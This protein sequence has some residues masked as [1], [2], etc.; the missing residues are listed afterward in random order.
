V[1]FPLRLVDSYLVNEFLSR[2][3]FWGLLSVVQWFIFLIPPCVALCHV[4][5]QAGET[6]S[7]FL[8]FKYLLVSISFYSV[9]SLEFKHEWDWSRITGYNH[10]G[11]LR[12]NSPLIYPA[13][14]QHV[15]FTHTGYER[16]HSGYA[17]THARRLHTRAHTATHVRRL[18]TRTHARTHADH[19]R[20]L[21]MH[22][23]RLRAHAVYAR[24]HAGYA[25]QE[26]NINWTIEKYY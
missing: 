4:I 2:S 17:R 24:A 18:Y 14:V 12:S 11:R 26:V 16:T 3:D 5:F 7:P 19:T 15:D 20:R 23:R 10:A 8:F 13:W 25:F 6:F 21:H 22:A 1:C 9:F